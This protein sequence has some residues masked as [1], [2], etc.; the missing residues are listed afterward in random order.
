MYDAQ[1]FKEKI[2][3]IFHNIFQEIETAG[4]FLFYSMKPKLL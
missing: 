2:I 3:S 1:K 4:C